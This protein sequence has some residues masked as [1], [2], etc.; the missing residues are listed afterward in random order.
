VVKLAVG[1]YVEFEL[2]TYTNKTP[3]Q[4]FRVGTYEGHKPVSGTIHNIWTDKRQQTW[5]SVKLE[6]GKTR[7]VRGRNLYGSLK[8]HKR[9]CPECDEF[10]EDDARVLSESRPM[11][12]GPCAYGIG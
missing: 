12:C 8:T 9:P 4:S 1:D 11:K 7:R 5:F 6:D 2:A 3:K 10:R